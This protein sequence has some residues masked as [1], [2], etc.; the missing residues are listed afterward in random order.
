MP[1]QK[2]ILSTRCT[3]WSSTE[4]GEKTLQFSRGRNNP[5][6]PTDLLSFTLSGIGANKLTQVFSVC[7][8]SFRCLAEEVMLNINYMFI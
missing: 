5:Q 3:T 4:T 8:N 7:S 6:E 2:A 1:K